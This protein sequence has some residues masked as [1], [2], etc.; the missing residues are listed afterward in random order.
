MHPIHSLNI[1][2]RRENYILR[3]FIHKVG[4]KLD[5]FAGYSMCILEFLSEI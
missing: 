2:Q 5:S 1:I 3:S 4:Y